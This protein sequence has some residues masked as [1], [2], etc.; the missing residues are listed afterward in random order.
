MA[1]DEEDDVDLR[2][3]TEDPGTDPIESETES[4][5]A[6]EA[7]E[8][9]EEEEHEA[10]RAA[11]RGERGLPAARPGA[12]PPPAPDPAAGSPFWATLPPF[13][14]NA[15]RSGVLTPEQALTRHLDNQR[16]HV[17]RIHRENELVR[18][19]L[20]ESTRES[21]AIQE[22]TAARV[23]RLLKALGADE[24]PAPGAVPSREEDEA[25]HVIGRLGQIEQQ[26]RQGQEELRQTAEQQRLEAE[27]GRRA[28]AIEHYSAA[29]YANVASQA[30]DY[31]Q[32][33]A[34]VV[35]RVFAEEA[36]RLAEQYPGASAADVNAQ[37]AKNV[38]NLSAVLQAQAAE[39]GISLASEVYKYARQLGYGHQAAQAA[40][41][42]P[43]TPARG[44]SRDQRRMDAHRERIGASH[45]IAGT[46]P[47]VT[48]QSDQERITAI[49]NFTDEEFEELFEGLDPQQAESQFKAILATHAV[50]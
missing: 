29:D 17:N 19:Q 3:E 27:L 45:T 38:V 25:G 24:P 46:A 4:D 34:F 5:E 15:V 26:V 2:E 13:Y 35:E 49:L 10:K 7:R 30:P 6:R 37:A 8:D 14:Q 18:R 48:P 36:L 1:Y 22:K 42:A 40:A 44:K 9:R 12:E 39:K 31:D 23:E 41:A 11:V 33:E 47:R 20:E 28:E 21:K 32:A 16:Q 43:A 50:G